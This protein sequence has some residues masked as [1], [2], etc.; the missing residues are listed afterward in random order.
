M[1]GKTPEQSLDTALQWLTDTIREQAHENSLWCVD[2]SG[3]GGETPFS[4]SCAPKVMTNRV[5]V[6]KQ[7]RSLNLMSEFS[8]FDFS[9]HRDNS[10]SQFFYRVSKEKP[11]THHVIN[12][13]ARLLQEGGQLFLCGLKNEGI[14]TYIEKAALRLGT[15]QKANKQGSIYTAILTKTSTAGP[16]LEDS[17]Y[18]QPRVIGHRSLGYYREHKKQGKHEEPAELCFYSKPGLFGWQKIDRGSEF[19]WEQ[20]EP[21]LAQRSPSSLLDL[22]CGYGYLGLMSQALMTKG[23]ITRL[24]LTDNNAGAVAMARH[25]LEMNQMTAE[26]V[27]ADCAQGINERFDV[28]LCNP[29]FHQ[30]FSVNGTLTTKFLRGARDH[31]ADNGLALFVVNAFIPLEKVAAPYFKQVETIARNNSFKVIALSGPAA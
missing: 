4:S 11:V 23:L 18:H 8:D 19:L 13:A 14:K 7:A 3:L 9:H 17:D 20:V 25:N 26:V 2:E 31:L 29:P 12:Q 28:I 15:A 16:E 30:G 27:A 1:S 6:Y 22:G 24:V 5:D 10:L 21:A